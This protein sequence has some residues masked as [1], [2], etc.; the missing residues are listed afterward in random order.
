MSMPDWRFRVLTTLFFCWGLAGCGL[1]VP[2][3]KELWDTDRPAD[4]QSERIPGTAQIEFEIKKH[5]FC[6]LGQAVKY[7][8]SHFPVYS[9]PS[10]NNLK[11]LAKYPIPPEWIAQISL[12]LQVDE[13]SAVSPG[14]TL[15]TTLPN[16]VRVFGPGAGAA[17]SVTVGQ[18]RTVGLGGTL[19]STATRIDKFDPSYAISYLMLPD[20]PNSVCLD[21]NDPFTK[22]GWKPASS[23]PFILDGNLGIQDWLTGAVITNTLIPSELGPQGGGNK[24]NKKDPVSGNQKDAS[25]SSGGGGQK[26]DTLTYE[27]KFIIVSNGNV[28]PTWKLVNVSANTSGTFFSTGR[29]RTHDLI[30]TIGPNDQ[31]TL[32][33]HLASQIGQ[34]VSGGNSTLMIPQQ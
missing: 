15:N 4:S 25:A 26:P 18:S 1:S 11:L 5:V 31:R 24:G 14:V 21:G 23:S 20:T 30:I 32:F 27:I 2:D 22:I 33:T 13:S 8:N 19:S 34:A 29:T 9:G 12:T 6:E 3:I 28:T 17:S 16:V 10:P 7:V